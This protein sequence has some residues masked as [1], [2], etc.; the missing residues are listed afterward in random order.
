M[1]LTLPDYKVTISV[2]I[3]RITTSLVVITAEL[4][5]PINWKLSEALVSQPQR[6]STGSFGDCVLFFVMYCHVS[7]IRFFGRSISQRRESQALSFKPQNIHIYS[8]SWGP[9]TSGTTVQGP[10]WLV[11]AALKNGTEKVGCVLKYAH[12]RWVSKNSVCNSQCHE[13]P[14]E[15]ACNTI[16]GVLSA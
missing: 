5:V 14:Y 9:V 10:G 11:K 3:A 15:S 2:T 16:F 1:L 7:G 12:K 8:N 4:S 6:T 13:I